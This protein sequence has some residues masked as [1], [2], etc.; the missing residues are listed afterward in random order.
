MLLV[1]MRQF[2]VVHMSLDAF[3]CMLKRFQLKEIIVFTIKDV[4]FSRCF[5]H[6]PYPALSC[7]S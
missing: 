6:Y 4:F 5:Q 2:P 3:D 1:I 7:T